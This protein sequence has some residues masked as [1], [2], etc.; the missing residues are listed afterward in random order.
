MVHFELKKNQ[1]FGDTKSTINYLFVSQLNSEQALY[2]NNQK[3]YLEL[4]IIW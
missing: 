2:T 4:L 1:A 3:F